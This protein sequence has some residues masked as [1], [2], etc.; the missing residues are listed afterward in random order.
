MKLDRYLRLSW[1]RIL[2]VAAAWVL[3]VVLHNAIYGL[4]FDYF[5]R[6]GGDE[7]VF[8]ILAVLVIPLYFAVSLVYTVIQIVRSR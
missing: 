6:T 5:N 3:A 7:P 4:F 2:I 8:F 1:R